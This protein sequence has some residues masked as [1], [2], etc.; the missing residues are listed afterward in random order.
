AVT[1]ECRDFAKLLQQTYIEQ[2]RTYGSEQG[3]PAEVVIQQILDDNLGPGVVQLYCPVSPGFMITPY[4]LE[5]KT[6][7][8]AIQEIAAQI[9]WYL[10]YRRDQ[11]TD[12]FK[13]TFME[14]PRSKGI[15]TAD[16]V[17]D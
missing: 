5:Y 4:Q 3:T 11:A 13:L 14:P 12:Q 2:V 6:V 9:G 8:D 16:F 10:G 1:C 7:W 17:L 15:D